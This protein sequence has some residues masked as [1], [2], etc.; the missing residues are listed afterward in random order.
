MQGIL[1]WCNSCQVLGD[2][3]YVCICYRSRLLGTGSVAARD[4]PQGL[5]GVLLGEHAVAPHGRRSTGSRA[6]APPLELLVLCIY[7]I[8]NFL[9]H[10]PSFAMS[11]LTN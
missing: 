4:H 7:I 6:A 2:L 3:V 10:E 1:I 5:P 9:P 11:R 8:V